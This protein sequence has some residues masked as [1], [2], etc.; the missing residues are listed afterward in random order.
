MVSFI[1]MNMYKTLKIYYLRA[2]VIKDNR[3]I[4]L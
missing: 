4:T 1:V 3:R 2:V